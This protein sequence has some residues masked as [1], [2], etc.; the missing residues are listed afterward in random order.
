LE[1]NKLRNVAMFFAH[2]LHSDA[3]PWTVL[4]YIKLSEQDTTSSSRIFIKV[5]FQTMAQFLG[6][7]KLRERLLPKVGTVAAA[8]AL[9]NQSG[10][11]Q[12]GQSNDWF[13]RKDQQGRGRGWIEPKTHW[14]GTSNSN[15][16]N[17]GEGRGQ[18]HGQD[19]IASSSSSIQGDQSIDAG[20]G[21]TAGTGVIIADHLRGLF[22][23]DNPH[24]ARFAILFFAHIGLK[25]LTL[26]LRRMLEKAPKLIMSGQGGID[27]YDKKEESESSELTSSES[28]DTTTTSSSESSSSDESSSS[29]EES[30]SETSSSSED[31]KM[32]KKKR[33]R[34][35]SEK[36]HQHHKHHN[37]H[38]HRQ[39]HRHKSKI[40]KGKSKH[41]HH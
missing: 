20:L 33:K 13:G 29:S 19:T 1:T 25:G 38:K 28:E 17:I 41:K 2:L 10:Q 9:A 37:N 31:Y 4:E 24:N 34:E 23:T 30:S 7:R 32:V 36:H 27:K 16:G 12:Q 39:E 26:E 5:L 21:G 14:R 40:D 18:I 8:A 22:P 15:H 35:E 6:I 3:L 11:Q